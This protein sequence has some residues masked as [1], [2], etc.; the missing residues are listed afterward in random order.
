MTASARNNPRHRLNNTASSSRKGAGCGFGSIRGGEAGEP[1]TGG[2]APPPWKPSLAAGIFASGCTAILLSFRQQLADEP[3][4]D[5]LA[6][7]RRFAQKR[8][9]GLHRRIELKTAD[10]NAPPHFTQDRKST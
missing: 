1:S 5:F 7:P 4:F 6:C 2:G 8:E 3:V 9:A 10:G